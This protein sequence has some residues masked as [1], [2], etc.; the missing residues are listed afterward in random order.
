MFARVGQPMSLHCG[1]VFGEGVTEG[2]M[3]LAQLWDSFQSLPLLPTRKLDL[4][5]SES[6][7]GAFVY[8]LGASEY[9]Q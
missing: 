5:G 7:V 2:T 3:P 8:V 1:T 9:L 6:Q 4:C